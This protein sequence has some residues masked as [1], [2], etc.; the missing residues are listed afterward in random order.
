MS[1][2]DRLLHFYSLVI[3]EAYE[4][5]ENFDLK[6]AKQIRKSLVQREKQVAKLIHDYESSLQLVSFNNNEQTLQTIEHQLQIMQSISLFNQTVLAIDVVS[7]TGYYMFIKDIIA[8]SHL[9]P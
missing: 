4:L 1:Y 8:N 6:H 3:D 5:E 9:L 7:P 2:F